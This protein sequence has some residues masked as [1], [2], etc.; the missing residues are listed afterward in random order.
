MPWPSWFSNIQS[1]RFPTV[2]S[3]SAW[4]M[5]LGRCTKWIQSN[6][7]ARA[8]RELQHLLN[9]HQKGGS[10][11]SQNGSMYPWCWSLWCTAL[12]FDPTT[13][14]RGAICMLGA[15]LDP[16]HER[17]HV[18]ICFQSICVKSLV[19][20]SWCFFLL[21]GFR[22]SEPAIW[23]AICINYVWL[24]DCH[25]DEQLPHP[26]GV[27]LG[28]WPTEILMEEILLTWNVSNLVDG[29]IKCLS[30]WKQSKHHFGRPQCPH[31]Y[32]WCS[33]SICLGIEVS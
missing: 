7:T 28:L 5:E 1:W 32:N 19:A 4:A 6:W 9:E 3:G 18:F 16:C 11:W 24:Y 14:T 12:W 31:W 8:S 2:L 23:G 17:R 30:R 21:P 10:K 13:H 29:E 25:S 15:W 27:M 26:A 33:C 20:T 22:I